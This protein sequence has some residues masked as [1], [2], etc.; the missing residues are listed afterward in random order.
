MKANATEIN[1][2]YLKDLDEIL[3]IEKVKIAEKEGYLDKKK[4]E[5]FLKKCWSG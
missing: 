4:S 5:E 3:L 2:Y 1:T